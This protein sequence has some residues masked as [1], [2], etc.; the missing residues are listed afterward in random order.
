[1]KLISWILI[2][3]ALVDIIPSTRHIVSIIKS[4]NP[5]KKEILINEYKLATQATVLFLGNLLVIVYCLI[6]MFKYYI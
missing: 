6:N 1:M 3:L 4:K 2:M 5:N